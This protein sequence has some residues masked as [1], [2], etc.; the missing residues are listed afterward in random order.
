VRPSDYA[1]KNDGE[2]SCTQRFLKRYYILLLL[3]SAIYSFFIQ[4]QLSPKER[5]KA[6]LE[7]L[8]ATTTFTDDLGLRSQLQSEASN[9][10]TTATQMSNILLNL[11]K[12]CTLPEYD[13]LLMGGKEYLH[14]KQGEVDSLIALYQTQHQAD[15]TAVH[16]MSSKIIMLSHLVQKQ[17]IE[18]LELNERIVEA[19]E[20]ADL[21]FEAVMATPII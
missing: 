3:P 5:V 11:Q 12:I 18:N 13:D 17:A 4:G 2:V 16:L 10:D 7:V 14:K 20:Q 21:N 15:C 8:K 9:V 6:D 1:I 19:F